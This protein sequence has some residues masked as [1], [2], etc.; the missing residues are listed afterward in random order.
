[1]KTSLFKEFEEVSSKA[2]TQQIQVELKGGDFNEKLLTKT[3]DGID[4]KPFYHLDDVEHFTRVSTPKWSIC[5]HFYFDEKTD[6]GIIL[7]AV[8]RGAEQI[9]LQVNSTATPIKEVVASLN[10]N[11]IQP[12]IAFDKI[13][14]SE[15]E[16][17][18][19][20]FA[21]QAIFILD[22]I[23]KLGKTGNWYAN[24]KTDFQFLKKLSTAENFNV[25]LQLKHYQNAGATHVQQLAYA[26]AHAN[27]YLNK[28]EQDAYLHQ[29]KSI[30]L[31]VAIGG[32]Y[33]FEI[34]K[35]RALRVLIFSLLNEYELDIPIKII[36]EPTTRNKTLYDYNV[37]ML[38]TTT[39][40]MS[41]ILG[42][43][44]VVCNSNY[45]A[46][47]QNE[48]EFA[49]R[50][51]RNQLLILKNESYFD[52]VQNPADGTYYIEK[53]TQQLQEQAL[54]VF[55][56]IEQGKGLIQQLFQGK[57]QKKIK[58]QDAKER[59]EILQGKKKLVGTN[60]YQN[61]DDVLSMNF[62]KNPFV[63]NKAKKTLIEPILE[64]RVAEE[65][66]KEQLAKTEKA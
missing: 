22:P 39:E 46:I 55:K 12:Y 34:S 63:E 21:G 35:L 54:S 5:Q 10:Q 19:A 6:I 8:N 52:K 25:T 38:R 27:E 57:I 60:A 20:T 64:R 47:Y 51:S 53:I 56:N 37:N 15:L 4:I 40:C 48:S 11:Q 30:H 29:I 17:L 28:A 23:A 50:I 1:M 42:G 31:Q 65:I 33:F 58:E 36:A 13:I 43:A 3:E 16:T 9:K 66:E 24:Q 32:N 7:D 26:L 49:N 18:I 59:E 2:W 41:A 44:D 61:K 45:D 62:E 14:F